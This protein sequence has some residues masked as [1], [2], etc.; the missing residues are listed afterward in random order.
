MIEG[1]D[2]RYQTL[3]GGTPPHPLAGWLAPDLALETSD[4]RTTRVAELVRPARGLLLDLTA[5]GAVAGRAAG[6]AD[7]AT[8]VLARC[9]CGP[10]PAAAVLIR[11]DGYVAWAAEVQSPDPLPGLEEALRAWFGEPRE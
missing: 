7:R 11:P 3:P 9:R 8:A 10:A 5:D 1:S 6:W 2:V 4:C